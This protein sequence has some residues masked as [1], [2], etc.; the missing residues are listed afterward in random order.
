MTRATRMNRRE[1]LVSGAV[2]SLTLGAP[3]S[4]W[5]M[6]GPVVGVADLLIPGLAN[7]RRGAMVSL[8][9]SVAEAS[10]VAPMAEVP[11]VSP[12]SQELFSWPF[13]TL[14]GARGFDPLP[15]EA[16]GNLRL[17]LREGGFLFIDD[18]SG[19]RDSDFDRSVRRECAR[20]LP[21]AQ[22]AP[23]GRDH[24]VYRAFFMV[25][26]ATGRVVVRPAMEGMWLG[27]VTPVLY[28][29][30]D[31]AGALLRGSDGR[32]ALEVVPGGEAQRLEATK[33]A[34]NIVLFALTSNYKRDAVH[35]RT[36]MSRMRRQGGYAE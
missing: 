14:F 30:N 10:S 35:V 6:G 7:P 26:A 29:G 12:A 33:L 32:P 18:A 2:A 4:A 5:A 13:V 1:V 15:D 36:L 25:R 3:R 34:M 9:E 24:A 8:L 22:L 28:S 21:G 20:I 11:E 17:Y 27:D 16:V 31:L 23:I 19:V